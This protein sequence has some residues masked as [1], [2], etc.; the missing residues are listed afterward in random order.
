[1]IY[2]DLE[3]G[4]KLGEGSFGDV[5]KGML[6]GQ[7]VA[8]K[9]LRVKSLTSEHI[10]EFKREVV[11]MGALRHPNVVNFLGACF[12]LP[13]LCIVCE[14]VN[15]GSLAELFERNK[16]EKAVLSTKLV[17]E[18]C[19]QIARGLCWLHHKNVIHRDLKPANIL[20]D[21]N[22]NTK[23]ADFGLSHVKSRK[24]NQVGDYGM[25][26]TCSYMA[27]EVIKAK[28]YG[29]KAD[30]YSFGMVLCEL[31]HG[32]YPFKDAEY[33]NSSKYDEAVVQ[34]LRP[35]IPLDCHP[36]LAKLI[37][38]C[39]QM[40]PRK[41]PS[42]DDIVDT[43]QDLY[44]LE[45]AEEE[46]GDDDEDVFRGF[47]KEVPDAVREWRDKQTAKTRKAQEE[48]REER[49]ALRSARAEVRSAK[50]ALAR[51]RRTRKTLERKLAV[52]R[53]T[54][55]VSS[56]L[57]ALSDAGDSEEEEG[58]MQQDLVSP[59]NKDDE[60]KMAMDI[61]DGDG[62]EGGSMR[63][64]VRARKQKISVRVGSLD[65]SSSSSQSGD[66]GGILPWTSLQSPR[67]KAL[68]K[69]TNGGGIS[70]TLQYSGNKTQ[71]RLEMILEENQTG[72][73]ESP[74]L[75]TVRNATNNRQAR[76]DA[77]NAGAVSTPRDATLSRSREW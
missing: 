25:A 75:A 39:W 68:H 9:R 13:H 58:F 26:G 14:Y 17:V 64:P 24:I 57:T 41:R 15:N 48:V 2:D 61:S 73:L 59:R 46:E 38:A 37:K 70:S 52:I 10:E 32:Y 1:V 77:R 8:L 53:D 51:E 29:V 74:E 3:F 30:V 60:K 36:T 49:K 18:I 42:M 54:G 47:F 16:K 31:V 55:M 33:E 71:S 50:Q 22:F 35:T 40:N 34:G 28:P 62:G 66:Q 4:E 76:R 23:L 5:F 72:S 20:I 19:M 56:D 7:E 63:T 65:G 21:N 43:L 12:R 45:F 44:E 6:W 69:R 67:V 27:P 11:I